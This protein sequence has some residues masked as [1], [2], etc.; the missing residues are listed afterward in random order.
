M[1]W[2]N[3]I[4][5]GLIFLGVGSSVCAM[6]RVREAEVFDE[7][8]AKIAK[9]DENSKIDDLVQA[10]RDNNENQIRDLLAKDPSL[11]NAP[12]NQG[13]TALDYALKDNNFRIV[14][15]LL[16]YGALV[17][18]I[19]EDDLVKASKPIFEILRSVKEI[20]DVLKNA[21]QDDLI[22]IFEKYEDAEKW[23]EGQQKIQEN[24]KLV[25]QKSDSIGYPILE[26]VLE[27]NPNFPLFFTLRFLAQG[28]KEAFDKLN[29]YLSEIDLNDQFFEII[30]LGEKKF[31]YNESFKADKYFNNKYLSILRAQDKSLLELVK[32]LK[33]END[34]VKIKDLLESKKFDLD[35]PYVDEVDSDSE[36]DS[37]SEVDSDSDID[38]KKQPIPKTL[39][40]ILAELQ[41][42]D[43]EQKQLIL[44]VAELL[45][46]YGANINQ[47][48][49][50]AD[51][52]LN[53]VFT[54][55]NFAVNNNNVD[56]ASFLLD[57][58]AE[59]DFRRIKDSESDPYFEYGS[60]D[61]VQAVYE[62]NEAMLRLLL[63]KGS[64]PNTQDESSG[65]TAL[66]DLIAMLN[67]ESCYEN[68]VDMLKNLLGYGADPALEDDDGHSAQSF[69]QTMKD[70]VPVDIKDNYIRIIDSLM[71]AENQLN[72]QAKINDINFLKDLDEDVVVILLK[73]L[74]LKEGI[75]YSSGDRA[76]LGDLNSSLLNKLLTLN[77][78]EQKNRLALA[79]ITQDS[80][81][82]EKL[83]QVLLEEKKS[84]EFLEVL[85][86]NPNLAKKVVD[87]ELFISI[88]LRFYED[89]FVNKNI[90]D[91]IVDSLI[92]DLPRSI[93][94]T[95]LRRF[96]GLYQGREKMQEKFSDID[97]ITQR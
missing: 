56:F 15:L 58:G 18:N 13:Q 50:F 40:M 89:I 35:S 59:R 39:L 74:L 85:A 79:G 53:L 61:L 14:F 71:D 47:F 55:L 78:E 9:Y 46:D 64:L 49:E 86:N 87:S 91:K 31:Y 41:P 28:N 32:S 72:N 34:V 43:S 33:D 44:K 1:K 38:D 92:K 8:E 88:L 76:L 96:R 10:V 11:L 66:I 97:V 57:K 52:G 6:K 93:D 82:M 60:T 68:A 25:S 62:C 21:Q 23:F 84:K 94:K 90:L 65:S 70:E 12:D 67:S 69:A 75:K 80:P 37:G 48:V 3:N 24:L 83:L 73:R 20:D 42:Q 5:F 27:V 30:G 95:A 54:P 77:R 17:Q 81:K 36:V 26:R 29:S 16:L 2:Y 45:L 4:V 51:G 63:E 22:S 19:D 7:R